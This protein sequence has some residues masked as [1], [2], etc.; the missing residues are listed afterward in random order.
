MADHCGPTRWEV[1]VVSVEPDED[2]PAVSLI[3]TDVVVDLQPP[4]GP[5]GLPTVI[6]DGSEAAARL[7]PRRVLSSSQLGAP[8]A[9]LE[10]GGPPIEV[11][12]QAS[13]GDGYMHLPPFRVPAFTAVSL[14]VE[15]ADKGNAAS[16]DFEVRARDL[17][18]VHLYHCSVVRSVFAL[19]YD[20]P[21]PG[22][23][24][25]LSPSRPSLYLSFPNLVLFRLFFWCVS[26]L[27]YVRSLTCAVC[28]DHPSH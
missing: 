1:D 26:T 11:E 14:F 6:P 9:K 25:S 8:N 28:T 23:V 24:L 15:S 4:L 17:C 3:D 5:D 21:I 27:K 7:G 2:T 19:Q 18:T 16:A 13:D 22:F 12:L 10:V 20:T